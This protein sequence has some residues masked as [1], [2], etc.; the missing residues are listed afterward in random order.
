M[1]KVKFRR[2]RVYQYILL[3]LGEGCSP[4][5]REICQDLNIPSTST[6]HSDLHY[7]VDKGMIEMDEGRNRTIRLPGAPGVHVPLVGTV[8]AGEPIL[9]TQNIEQY[10][11]IA[12]LDGYSGENELFAL[13]VRG[14]SMKNAAILH[15]DI[16]VVKQV[17][18]AENGEIV[19][20]MVNDEATVKRF[21]KENGQYR[22]QPEND[23]YEPIIVDEVSIVGKVISMIRYY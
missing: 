17:S 5:V 2:E 18:T 12:M 21:Y 16:I 4:T 20:A 15:G 10:L 19:V 14:D 13:R 11:Q 22:L 23:D 7:L 1:E 9:A 6:V 3:R 8:T